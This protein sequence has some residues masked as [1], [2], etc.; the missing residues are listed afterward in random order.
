MLYRVA[1]L[2]LLFVVS[3]SL[4]PLGLVWASARQKFTPHELPVF[5]KGLD[6]L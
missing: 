3:V 4:L 6:T 2:A 1:L 5:T